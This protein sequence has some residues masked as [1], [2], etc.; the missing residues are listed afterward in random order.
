MVSQM[1]PW[2]R[3]TLEAHSTPPLFALKAA[4]LNLGSPNSNSSWL[5]KHDA[6]RTENANT[7]LVARQTVFVLS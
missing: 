6:D 7:A 2:T 4:A 5:R 1:P 3:F